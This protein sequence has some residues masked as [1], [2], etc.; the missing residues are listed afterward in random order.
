MLGVS[1]RHTFIGRDPNK[2]IEENFAKFKQVWPGIVRFAQRHKVKIAIE[3]C[4]M[5]FTD[6]ECR[7]KEPR[8][9]TGDYGEKCLRRFHQRAL[10]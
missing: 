1:R 5:Y 9:Y 3:N 2:N 6:D 8:Q 4:P 10:A 7:R